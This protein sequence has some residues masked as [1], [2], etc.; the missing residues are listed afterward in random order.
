MAELRARSLFFEFHVVTGGSPGKSGD[1]FDLN[2]I[3]PINIKLVVFVRIVKGLLWYN[4]FCSGRETKGGKPGY[5]ILS[6]PIF[7]S[8]LREGEPHPVICGR[9]APA[10][11]V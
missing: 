10:Y 3:T 7:P 2:D 5:T 1:P 8:P 4:I 11:C 6:Y 9:H